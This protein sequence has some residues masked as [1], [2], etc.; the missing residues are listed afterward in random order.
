MRGRRGG[1]EEEARGLQREMVSEDE[2]SGRWE[3]ERLRVVTQSI[4]GS[5]R[6]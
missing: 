6:S 5:Q 4:D 2:R 1:G 3:E